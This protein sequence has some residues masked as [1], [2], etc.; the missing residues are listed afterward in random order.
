[1]FLLGRIR[2]RTGLVPEVRREGI[3]M[4]DERDEL[5]D[6]KMPEKGTDG[7]LTL[8]LA[9]YLAA[10]ARRDA[11]NGSP[12]AVGWA[13]LERHAAELVARHRKHWRKDVSEPGAE[14]QLCRDAVARLEA[15]HLVRRTPD[16]VQP[17]PVIGRYAVDEA[18]IQG[19]GGTQG[20][21]LGLLGSD[22]GM[23][24]SGR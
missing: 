22:P 15:L 20:S 3:A 23:E 6:Q 14:A 18:T 11:G 17:R 16:G 13:A 24:G 9:E 2:E 8:L 1:S 21:L 10:S 19:E 12:A 4:V 5:S 7:H